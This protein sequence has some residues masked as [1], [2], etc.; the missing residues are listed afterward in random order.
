[1]QKQ[2][3]VSGKSK[4]NMLLLKHL[5]GDMQ[6]KELVIEDSIANERWKQVLKENTDIENDLFNYQK[7]VKS[8]KSLLCL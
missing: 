1:M 7:I 3:R 6:G 4:E 2:V 8:V 5:K